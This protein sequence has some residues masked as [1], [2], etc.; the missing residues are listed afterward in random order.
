VSP[1]ADAPR[2]GA[3]AAAAAAFGRAAAWLLLWAALLPA[4]GAHD[5]PTDTRV[6]AFARVQ[7]D[8]LQV[9][10][11]M[12][13][14]LLLNADLPKQG[15]GY[16]ALAQIDDG[17]AR[18]ADAIADGVAWSA[19]GRELR[20][21]SRR[22]R[23]SLPADP[24]F[25]SYEQAR[26]LVHGPP[27]A[28]TNYVFWNQGYVDVHYEYRL[29]SPQA[30]VALDFRVAPA[31][32][33]RVRLDLRYGLADGGERGFELVTAQGPVTLD[34]RWHQ[35]AWTFLKAGFAHILDGP[36]HL[37]FLLCL[38][39]PFR[40]LDG[41]LVGVVSAF[42][43]AHSVTLIGSAYGLAP[44]GAWF[45][46]LVE[47]GIALSILW[48]AIEN[49][50]QPRLERRWIW[51]AAFGLVHGFGFS[52]L[53]QSQL[54]FAGSNLLLSLL[55]FNVGVELGQLL[56][57]ALLLPL[58]VAWR[59]RRPQADRAITIVVAA[60]AAHVAW[61]WTSE[62]AE[63]LVAATRREA[64]PWPPDAGLALALLA[65]LGLVAV[66]RRWRPSSRLAG[67]GGRA[68]IKND[69]HSSS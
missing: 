54:Q 30:S 3:G 20:P 19:D 10:V 40:R 50:L 69:S 26:A 15:P 18:A 29:P 45:P 55:A 58:L 13:L 60:L 14:A 67:Q 48:M 33:D 56:V 61:H 28:P 1:R 38:V 9:L 62:R 23:I 59:A 2:R 43:V 66:L 37:L 8:R 17:L 46:P 24:S 39:L 57:L 63:A 25:A 12:P 34:P 42:T 52:F 22:A 65:V 16:L 5:L 11:R 44:P 41:Y 31:L 21:E 51:S 47:T 53:L 36:D 7:G 27:L 6:H 35:A 4:A 32:G 49:L 68:T 64:W